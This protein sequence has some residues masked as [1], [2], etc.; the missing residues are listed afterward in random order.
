[1]SIQEEIKKDELLPSSVTQMLVKQ[2]S[3]NNC[4]ILAVKSVKQGL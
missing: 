2:Q 1:M 3:L 4:S